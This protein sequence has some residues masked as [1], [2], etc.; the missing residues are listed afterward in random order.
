MQI[1]FLIAQPNM[2]SSRQDEHNFILTN[3]FVRRNAV[4][5]EKILGSH[6]EVLRAIVLWT[7]FECESPKRG[8][9][10]YSVL[11]LVLLQQEWLWAGFSSES[12]PSLG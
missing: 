4:S 10:P 7:N 12:R 2:Q 5:R 1:T 11:T 8:I 6:H 3:V 9:T